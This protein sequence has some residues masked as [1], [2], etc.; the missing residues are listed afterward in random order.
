MGAPASDK[1]F[2]SNFFGGDGSPH[3]G[4]QYSVGARGGDFR[5]N[6]P[7]FI[8]G[9]VAEPSAFRLTEGDGTE[10]LLIGQLTEGYG[11]A[12]MCSHAEHPLGGFCQTDISAFN[13]H[14]VKN[15]DTDGDQVADVLWFPPFIRNPNPD[16]GGD[17]IPPTP[18]WK[19][20][21][22][23]NPDNGTLFVDPQDPNQGYWADLTYAHGRPIAAGESMRANIESPR[24]SAQVF[25]QFDDLFHDNSIFSP[26][27][28][29][30]PEAALIP[31]DIDRDGVVGVVD[32]LLLLGAWGPCDDNPQPCP[33]DL[34]RDGMV[35]VGDLLVL[36]ANYG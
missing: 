35:G 36:L 21:L 33:A 17:I 24:A 19:P 34:D 9:S 16:A 15:I 6:P 12:K 4:W 7:H 13:P 32:L 29:F 10:G 31:G 2:I 3:P 11:V 8:I 25:Y 14:G 22:W 18:A 23:I 1:A 30:A 20:F 5:F 26:H 28:N 27:P